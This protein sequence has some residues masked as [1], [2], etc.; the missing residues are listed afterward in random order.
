M[1]YLPLQLLNGHPHIESANDQILTA[2][3]RNES[4]A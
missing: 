4:A 2:I 1:K 3:K